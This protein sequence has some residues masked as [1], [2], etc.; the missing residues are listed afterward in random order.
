MKVLGLR[1]KLLLGIV[2]I[3][4]V[5]IGLV[6][7]QA[8]LLFQEDKSS[9]VFDLNASE[10]I[11]IADEIQA[12]VR[13]LTEKMR[14]LYDAVR[15][16]VPPGPG[17]T[18]LLL[19]MLRQ[20]PEFLLLSARG[21][22]GTLKNLSLSQALAKFGLTVEA[23]HA[24]YVKAVPFDTVT[25]ERPFVARLALASGAATFTLAVR[26]L[27]GGDGRPGPLLVAEIPLDRLY[28]TRSESRLFE[29][30]VTDGAGRPLVAPGQA[31]AAA[32]G[33]AAPDASPS[34]AAPFAD[35]LP[36]TA[37]TAGTREYAAA[38]VVMLAAYAPVGDIGLWAVVQIPRARAFE[39]ARRLVTRSL[40]L[41]G[42]VCLAAAGLVLFF[43]SSITRPLVALTRATEQIGRG[44]FDVQIPQSGG[45]EIAALGARFKRMTE[46]LAARET[47]LKEANKRL[48]ESEKMTALGQLGAGIAHEVKNPMTSIRGYA[49]MGIR[50]VP[51]GSP[52]HEYFRTI[53]KETG[54]SLDILKNLL[55]FSRQETAEMGLID[56]NAVVAD[57][58][59]LVTHQLEM[60]KVQVVPSP[61]EDPLRVIGNANQLEQVLLNLCMNAGDAME[62]GGTLTVSTELVNNG[63]LACIRVADTGSGIPPDVLGRIFDPFFTT[64]PV[65]KGT[66]LGLSVSYGIVKEHKGEISVESRPGQGT[67]FTILIPR[68]QQ[69]TEAAAEP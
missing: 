19:S 60:K 37:R 57:T 1:A 66:G 14:I 4:C 26:A 46:E 45:D 24:G 59:H 51:E 27:A 65:G 41:A 33:A 17:R 62:K 31:A 47:A 67:T 7:G 64:K 6:A 18:D 50:K 30:Y 11:K 36:K 43:S 20:Y 39:A 48:V 15:L 8:V 42:L 2:L 21:D 61:S 5:S 29:V 56:L 22:D 28:A 10:A 44:H 35:L 49:Q 13:H 63:T 58:L 69:T 16:P 25:V 32:R 12:N 40:A 38:G 55:K 34:I 9:Y 68:V 3:L 53:E 23:A 52:L 54:R